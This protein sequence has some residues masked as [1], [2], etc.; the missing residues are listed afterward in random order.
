[1]KKLNQLVRERFD[2]DVEA[3][4]PYTDAQ[5]TQML[6][7]L[8][9]ASGLTSRISIMENVKGSEDIKLLTSDPALQAATS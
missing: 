6:T 2:Y 9:Y 5:S 7:D 3:L 1:M 8:I 4:A